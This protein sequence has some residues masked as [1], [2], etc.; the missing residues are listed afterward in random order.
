M[1]E[2]DFVKCFVVFALCLVMIQ[3]KQ[4]CPDQYI[5]VAKDEEPHIV[6][7]PDSLGRK[8]VFSVNTYN[9]EAYWSGDYMAVLDTYMQVNPYTLHEDM[10]IFSRTLRFNRWE[11]R[12]DYYDT[13]YAE[14]F[15]QNDSQVSYKKYF[16]YP[17]AWEM[18][19][20]KYFQFGMDTVAVII[21]Y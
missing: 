12:D 1:S 7:N 18:K 10:I 4:K 16:E 13:L 20:M 21:K 11:L 8:T 9:G 5:T 15:F 6:R 2:R 17:D 19:H 3:C 14:A